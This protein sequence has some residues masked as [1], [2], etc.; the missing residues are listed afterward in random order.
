MGHSFTSFND[1]HIRSKDYKV[2]TWLFLICREIEKLSDKPEWL[3]SAHEKWLS[4]ARLSINGCMDPEFDEILD[5]NEK[6]EIITKYF[7]KG[8]SILESF[9][10]TISKE[11]LNEVCEKSPPFHVMEDNEAEL[12]LS[13][14]RAVISLLKGNQVEKCIST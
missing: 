3:R 11:F 2:E 5:T 12:Y 4:E 8:L 1:K 6:V 14:G 13:Y 9:G 7:E 10:G